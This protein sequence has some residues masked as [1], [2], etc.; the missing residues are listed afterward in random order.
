VHSQGSPVMPEPPATGLRLLGRGL[1]RHRRALACGYPLIAVWQLCETLVPVAIGLVVDR[2]VATGD[3]GQFGLWMLVLAALFAVLSNAYRFGSRFVFTSQQQE[4]HLL[5]SEIARHVLHPRG[6]RTPLLPGE[7]LALATS[8]VETVAIVLR[9]L[10]FAVAALI[11][12]LVVAA[13]VLGVDLVLGLLILVGVPTVVLVIQGVTPLVAR[14][15]S[16]QQ[17]STA[18]A[19]GLA[20][21]LVQGL[22]PLKGIGGEDI[23]LQRYR[24]A[25][26]RARDDTIGVARSW[27][28][29]TGLTTGLSALLLAAV[30]AVAGQRALD[31]DISVG[32]LIALVGLTQFL[33]EPIAGL[34]ELS[35]QFAASRASAGRITDFLATP[36]ILA[37][38]SATPTVEHPQLSLRDVAAGPLVD[39][40][41]ETRPGELL[42]LLVDDPATSAALVDLVAGSRAAERGT[43]ALGDVPLEDLAVEARHDLLLVNTHHTEIFE[44]TLRSAIDPDGILDAAE[45]DAVLRASAADEVV[46]LHPDGLDRAVRAGGTSLSG[47]QRQR[48]AL[49]R[50]LASRAPVLLLQDPTTAVDSVTEQAIADGLHALRASVGTTVLITSSP[51]LLR[52]A[53]RVI[54]VCDGRVAAVGTHTEL[55]PDETYRQAVLR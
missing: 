37:D 30:T 31:G 33:A 16:R 10:A 6:A 26:L 38:G 49:A 32:Q 21:D 43:V 42:A 25:S 54:L 39:I 34:G 28:Y 14:R 17:Q 22:R 5:R 41:F 9:Q 35:A 15:S 1:L 18:A 23:A 27:G 20:G 44:G 51:A 8:D 50:A 24:V 47:G 55:M 3:A 2:G 13:Y 4:A 53:D 29:L 45:L 36:R 12:V 52:R 19:S 7:T 48:L 46:A 11:S 40:S